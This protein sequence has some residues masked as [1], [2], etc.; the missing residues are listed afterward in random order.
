M[1]RKLQT[2]VI[3]FLKGKGAYVIKTRPGM[4]TPTGCPDIIFMFEGAWGAIEV[5]AS[6]TSRWQSGQEATLARLNTWCP[7]AWK[8]YPENWG[9]I[10][11]ILL[12][13]FF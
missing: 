9:K 6:R 13:H 8:V 11:Q 4:G 5:K 3:K 2:E 10:K 12:T 7:F 1:E